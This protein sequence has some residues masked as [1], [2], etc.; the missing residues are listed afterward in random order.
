MSP[1][2]RPTFKRRTSKHPASKHA[3]SKH[4]NNSAESPVR[5]GFLLMPDY[6]MITFANAIAVLRM[7]NRQSGRELYRWTTLTLDGTAVASSDGLELKSDGAV[8]DVEPL[9][10][11]FVCGG[12]HIEKQCSKSLLDE[13]RCIAQRDIPLGAFCTGSYAL[14]AA[15]R[16]CSSFR[17]PCMIYDLP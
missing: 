4:T 10:M 16:P 7:A 12:Y 13:L 5:I 6:T 1:Y 17:P 15:G 14:A 9:D 8:T 3:T 2:Q 11:L